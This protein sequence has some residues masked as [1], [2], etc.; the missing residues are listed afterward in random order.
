MNG[1]IDQRLALLAMAAQHARL[2]ETDTVRQALL[3]VRRAQL[4]QPE[5]VGERLFPAALPAPSHPGNDEL[6]KVIRGIAAQP[7][8]ERLDTD[9]VT[10]RRE[11]LRG[12]IAAL[13]E[14]DDSDRN[15]AGRTT[16]AQLRLD[17]GFEESRPATG[18][19]DREPPR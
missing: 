14:G 7:E 18:A 5:P 15:G 8:F 12:T 6:E 3:Y 16:S 17:A 2:G 9:A 4:S 13:R 19:V 10:G 1:L 11:Q